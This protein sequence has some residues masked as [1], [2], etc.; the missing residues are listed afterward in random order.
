MKNGIKGIIITFLGFI[1]ILLTSFYPD[2]YGDKVHNLS[3]V[4]G[5]IIMGFGALIYV[6]NT[7]INYSENHFE[8]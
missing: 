1:L 7:K 4:N 6:L 5:M 2:L 8:L 3:P